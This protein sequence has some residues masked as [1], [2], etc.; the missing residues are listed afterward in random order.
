MYCGRNGE[1]GQGVVSD[2]GDVVRAA[3]V[4]GVGRARPED[5]VAP[6]YR[7]T[8]AA[9]VHVGCEILQVT[10][11]IHHAEV[12][13]SRGIVRLGARGGSAERI[14]EDVLRPCGGD[15]EGEGLG[16]LGAEDGRGE[17]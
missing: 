15:G 12:G 17:R 16:V 11:N 5:V 14:T 7:W 3:S 6:G 10:Y 2:H 1:N 9:E 13:D 4:T 8:R